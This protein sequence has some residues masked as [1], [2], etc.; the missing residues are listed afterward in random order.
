MYPLPALIGG[1][2]IIDAADRYKLNE[3]LEHFGPV[4]EFGEAFSSIRDASLLARYY[5]ELSSMD[6]EMPDLVGIG[7]YDIPVFMSENDNG[8]RL[9]ERAARIQYELA[10]EC[11]NALSSDDSAAVNRV[12]G[13]WR[14]YCAI[15]EAILHRLQLAETFY[16]ELETLDGN[17]EEDEE[18]FLVFQKYH[19]RVR[20]MNKRDVQDEWITRVPVEDAPPSERSR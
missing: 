1:A 9:V 7:N 14:S 18:W 10:N 15:T 6:S 11:L 8:L 4:D 16:A 5:T 20:E 12:T 3:A 17:P 13:R 19:T 2:R